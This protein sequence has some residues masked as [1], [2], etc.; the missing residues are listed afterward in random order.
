MN[1]KVA[2]IIWEKNIINNEK[3][4]CLN[5]SFVEYGIIVGGAEDSSI[6]I[7]DLSFYFYFFLV[8]NYIKYLYIMKIKSNGKIIVETQRK[9]SK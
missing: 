8:L 4:T 2:R 7:W 1:G 5:S 6:K 3:I 9:Q